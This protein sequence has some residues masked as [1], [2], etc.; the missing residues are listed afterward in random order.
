MGLFCQ[1]L[2]RAELLE[3]GATSL[4]HLRA[5]A[6]SP[7]RHS[8]MT[9]SDRN[10]LNALTTQLCDSLDALTD[11]LKEVRDELGA[12]QETLDAGRGVRAKPTVTG[13]VNEYVLVPPPPLPGPSL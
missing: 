2:S 6:A 10:L 3:L 1:L 5:A 12:R 9:N 8:M 4:A 11:A 13:T 7:E